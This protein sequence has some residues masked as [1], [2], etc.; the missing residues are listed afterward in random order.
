LKVHVN[1]EDNDALNV[2][3]TSDKPTKDLQF[4]LQ[5]M[6]EPLLGDFERAN[7]EMLF[8]PIVPFDKGKTYEIRYQKKTIGEFSIRATKNTVK[9]TI[10]AIYPS[11][12][13]VPENLLKMY[14]VF[15]KPMQEVQNALD[16]IEVYNVTDAVNTSIFLELQNELWNKEH[17]ELTLW[18]DPGRIKTD[19]IPNRNHGL[20]LEAGK[21]YKITVSTEWTDAQNN[22][23]D[24]VYVKKLYVDQKDRKF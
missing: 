21:E 1:Y 13:T 15:S 9:P 12:D 24:K 17:T 7:H 11:R 22:K 19:L 5:G 20:P 8:R 16:F 6:R 4:F 14:L 23:L 2:T 3:F 10:T 18:L